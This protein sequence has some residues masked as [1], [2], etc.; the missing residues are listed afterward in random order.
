[1]QVRVT[2]LGCS[3]YTALKLAASVPT[4]S[5]QPSTSTNSRILNGA[6]TSI[7]ESIIMPIDISTLATT[8]SMMMKGMKIKKPIS[9]AVLSSLVMNEATSTWNGTSAG[10]A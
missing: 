7:G 8:R 9:N 5:T 6:E 1:M 3:G 10:P 4:A 2:S